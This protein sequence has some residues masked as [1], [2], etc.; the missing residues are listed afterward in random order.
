MGFFH[1][2]CLHEA[3]LLTALS[4][5]VYYN[6]TFESQRFQTVKSESSS[7]ACGAKDHLGANTMSALILH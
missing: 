7:C 1:R 3:R 4:L 6:H 5:T 2:R